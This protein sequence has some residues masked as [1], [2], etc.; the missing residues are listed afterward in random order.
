MRKV[1]PALL[2]VILMSLCMLF[3]GCINTNSTNG[4]STQTPTM[5]VEYTISGDGTYAA[6]TGCAGSETDVVISAVFRGLPVTAI[7][8]YAFSECYNLRSVTIPSSIT[9]IGYGAFEYCTSLTSVTIPDSVTTIC[10]YA[11]YNCSSLTTINYRGTESQWNDISKGYNWNFSTGGYI[12]IY[13]G[14]NDEVVGGTAGV[15]YALNGIYAVVTGFTGTVTDAVILDYYNGLPVTSISDYAFCYCTSLTS[16]VIPESVTTIGNYAF[17]GCNNLTTIN[18]S[19][20]E[21]QWNDISKGY[22]WDYDTGYYTVVCSDT[23]AGGEAIVGTEGL[24]YTSNGYY[25]IVTDYTGTETNVVIADTYMGVP[26]TTIGD[27]AF[28]YCTNIESVTI[29][30]SV[31]TIDYYAFYGCYNLIAINYRG[32]ES[33]WN[34]I[35]KGYDWNYNTGYYTVI[36]NYTGA[37][38]SEAISG[39]A[40]VQYTSNGAYATVTGYTG[41]AADIVI[42]NTYMGVP[43]TAIGDYAFYYYSNLTSVTIPDSVTYIGDGAFYGCYCLT[44]VTIPNSV[45]TIGYSAFEYCESLTSVTIPDNVTSIY[46]YAFYRCSSLESVT[47]G[48]SV[49]EIGI[50]AFAYCGDLMSVTIP[51]SVTT[52]DEAAFA[53]CYSLY[54]VT[55]PD[56]VTTI[57]VAAFSGCTNLTSVTIPYSVTTIGELAFHDCPSLT[58]ITVSSDNTAYKSVDGNLYTKDGKTLIQYAVGR[59]DASFEIP[60][61]VEAISHYAFY[62]CAS[63]ESVTIGKNVTS[64]G[65]YAFAYCYSLTS[66]NYRD[67]KTQ[68]LNISKGS[69]WDYNTG[70]YTITYRYNN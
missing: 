18:Y 52:I 41:S 12:V 3:T 42:A 26:V 60:D 57:D 5:G 54:S 58:S 8:D 27:S 16:V 59:S 21:S 35:S 62:N 50:Y 63:L 65:N 23:A 33:Q 1:I 64:I 13:E 66:I 55:I 56:S 47:I 31:I 46:S 24:Q 67:T 30:A 20:T 70:S 36:Y 19:G 7:S 38:N 68:W 29:P 34:A 32:T 11:F 22:E 28:Y 4:P 51:Y 15:Q 48:N 2:I 9:S 61:T 25:A 43:V 49:T 17:Y 39:T 10:D 45:T 53:Y 37:G 6:V 44:S 69:D 40:G 14:G